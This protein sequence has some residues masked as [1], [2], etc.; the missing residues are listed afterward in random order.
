METMQRG[1]IRADWEAPEEISSIDEI[2]VFPVFDETERNVFK[3]RVFV[4]I[5]D[6]YINN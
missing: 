4:W 6:Q 2:D 1:Q 3:Q 5:H